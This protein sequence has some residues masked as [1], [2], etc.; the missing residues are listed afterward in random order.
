MPKERQEWLPGGIEKY[1]RSAMYKK[2]GSYKKLGK[3]IAAKNSVAAPATK[4]KKIGGAK[5]G[6]SRVV[7]VTKESRY[8]PVVDVPVTRKKA[9]K[10]TIKFR[11]SLKPGAVCILLSG[12]FKGKRTVLLKTLPSGLILVTGPF[13]LNGVPLKR[14]DPSYVI[15]TSTVL[16]ISKVALPESLTD[17]F[18]RRPDA[19][20]AKGEIFDNKEDEGKALD[21]KRAALQKEVDAGVLAA[22]GDPTMTAYLRNSFSLRN[23]QFPHELVF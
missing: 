5:N 2:K 22:A 14:V 20:G 17:E 19:S 12:R 13:K 1:S 9:K 11:E 18:F 15:A 3:P 10:Q 23:G 8:Y 7:A 4:E 21:P 6:G 16:D